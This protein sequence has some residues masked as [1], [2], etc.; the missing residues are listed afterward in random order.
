[1]PQAKP[2][3]KAKPQANVELEVTE[4]EVPEPKVSG[5]IKVKNTSGR[6]LNLANGSISVGETGTA[7]PAEA[8]TLYMLLERV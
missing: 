1:M 6:V 2:Q 4:S 3:A 5:D 8:S 7:T